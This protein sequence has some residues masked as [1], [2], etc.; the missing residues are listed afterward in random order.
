MVVDGNG[1]SPAQLP[2]WRLCIADTI[3]RGQA[4]ASLGSVSRHMNEL[5]ILCDG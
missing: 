5:V 2:Y 1:Y 4:I 3:V